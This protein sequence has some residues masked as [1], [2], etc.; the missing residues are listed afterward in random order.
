MQPQHYFLST[1]SAVWLR[2]AIFPV[3]PHQWYREDPKMSE[4]KCT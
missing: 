2:Q 3:I 4:A 1:N